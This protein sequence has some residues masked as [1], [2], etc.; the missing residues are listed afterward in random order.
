MLFV[1][2]RIGA[3]SGCRD[4]CN[5]STSKGECVAFHASSRACSARRALAAYGFGAETLG[6][7][8]GGLRLT[9]I[10]VGDVVSRERIVA[11][12]LLTQ[13]NIELL[14]SS[15]SRVWPVDDSPCF[16]GL[17]QAIDEADRSL[18]RERDADVQMPDPAMPQSERSRLSRHP[19]ALDER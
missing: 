14:G 4:R 2:K 12:G 17:L 10:S 16:H 13:D 15:L 5:R 3:S 11:V 7:T 19:V 9:Y 8:Y 1:G 18:W 6:T